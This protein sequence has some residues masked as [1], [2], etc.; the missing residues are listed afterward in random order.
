[1]KIT[2]EFEVSEKLIEETHLDKQ[3]VREKLKEHIEEALSELDPHYYVF[4]ID[5][6]DDGD[7]SVMN[8]YNIDNIK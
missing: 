6:S 8:F 3:I 4:G 7:R 1:M 5:C 2:L